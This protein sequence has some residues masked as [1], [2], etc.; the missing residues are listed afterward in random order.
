[1]SNFESYDQNDLFSEGIINDAIKN[2]AGVDVDELKADLEYDKGL[3]N[4]ASRIYNDGLSKAEDNLG[5]IDKRLKRY[6]VDTRSIVARARNSVL[7]FPIY[8]TQT[9]RVNEAQI[10]AGLFERVYTTLVQT[11]LS[12]NQ[13][14]DEDE[15]NNLV[16]LKKYHT[17]LK[18]AAD[19]IANKYY[20]PIDD[21]DEMM[22]NS[23]F[24]SQKINENCDVEFRVI[25][26]TDKDLI[27]ENARL[28][29]EPLE[30]FVYLKEHIETTT[31]SRAELK[32]LSKDDIS[33]IAKELNCSDNDIKTAIKIN[34]T[35]DNKSISRAIKIASKDEDKLTDED[36]EWIEDNKSFF[37]SNK[38]WLA[39]N[40]EWFTKNHKNIQNYSFRDGSYVRK[41]QDITKSTKDNGKPIDAPEILKDSD[42]KK[43][44]NIL[45]Y[46]IS[47]TFRIRTRTGIER[48]VKYIIG[49]KSV[50]HLIRT[51]D[52]LEDLQEL[53]T[54][55]IKSLQKVRY[56]TGEIKFADYFFNIK[57]LKADAAK[58]INHNKKWINTLKRL[59]EYHKMNGSIVKKPMSNNPIPNGTLI[60]AQPDVTMLTNE[61]G[62]DLSKV[63]NAKRLAKSLFLIAVVIVDSSAGSMRVL[64][65]DTDT[66]WDVQ[67]LGAI[68]SE[69]AKTDNSQLMREINRMVNR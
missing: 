5:A 53:V 36:N 21:L 11:V 13:I 25:P 51:Q 24:Y 67:S 32:K 12:H 58:N 14:L 1:M 37:N 50:L 62:I 29:N 46:T 31:T 52:L 15:A 4:K 44:N 28:I 33:D 27:M 2:A 48:D 10:I 55:N 49:I 66:D 3:A 7:Q 65:P 68:E 20:E 30:G 22:Y 45:P 9:L 69:L 17:N 43:L 41:Q 60:L 54:G 47:A 35:I 6:K 38:K 19:V 64:F 40:K 42:I 63:S 59:S 34:S 18:E 23:I 39:D 57:N 61:T 56:K 16:F 26:C 8:V